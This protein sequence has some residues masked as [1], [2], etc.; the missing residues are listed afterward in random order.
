VPK[1]HFWISLLV[2][3][4]SI[5]AI[6]PVRGQAI[7]PHTLQLDAEQLEAIGIGLIQEA[8]RWSRFQQHDQALPRAELGTQLLPDNPQAWGVLG[9]LYVQ[10]D[11]IE[12]GIAALEKA[13][14]LDLNNAAI[15]F[16]LGS[17]YFQGEQYDR[18]IAEL[19]AGL[20]IEPDVPGALFDLGN[21]YYVSGNFSEAIDRYEEAFEQNN[22]FWPAINNIGLVQYEMGDVNRAMQMWRTSSEIAPREAEP[23]LAM[24]VALYARGD[25]DRA[26]PLA[27]EAL[28]LDVRYAELEFLELNL[29]GDRLLDAA[30]QLLSTPRIQAVVAQVEETTPLSIEP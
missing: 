24:A 20:D 14:S 27:E 2:A 16:A 11:R 5:V 25:V 12:E 4:S 26:I 17:A 22:D 29:W 23:K 18:A 28:Q 9:S 1:R 15:R 30:R 10:V 7:L 6:E 13:R 8:D 19:Q 3:F 21:A